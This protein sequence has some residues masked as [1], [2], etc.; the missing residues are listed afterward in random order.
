M[1][2]RREK[3]LGLIR[4][5]FGREIRRPFR[6]T[7]DDGLPYFIQP[8]S[9]LRRHRQE[10]REIVQLAIFLDQRQQR[11]FIFQQICLVEQPERWRAGVRYDYTQLPSDRSQYERAG[12][13]YL[14]FLPSEFSLI[15]LQGRQARRFGLRGEHSAG[16]CLSS[17]R[18]VVG[19]GNGG[20]SE[21]GMVA[22]HGKQFA[23]HVRREVV[24]P[25]IDHLH[26]LGMCAR[27][28]HE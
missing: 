13:A 27:Q 23:R 17:G 11:A 12:L 3:P 5:V 18:S 25:A 22:Q 6:Q 15:S 24:D 21:D 14:T 8:V 28:D 4:N 26:P 20:T 19:H 2:C 16:E 9:I 7:L 10:L 1:H